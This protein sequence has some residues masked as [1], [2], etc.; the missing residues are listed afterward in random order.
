MKSLQEIFLFYGTDK[1]SHGYARVYEPLLHP[2][3]WLTYRV[4]EVG[5]GTMIPDAPSS[6]VGYAGDDYKPGA[7]LRA[8]REYFPHAVIWGMDPAPDTQFNEERIITR[9]ADSTNL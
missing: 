6:M 3:K 7:S 8:W 9:R 5:I 1:A 2:R 4:L